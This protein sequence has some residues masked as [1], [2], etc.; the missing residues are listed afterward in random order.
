MAPKRVAG[1][2]MRSSGVGSG[3]G[4]GSR[5]IKHSAAPK[6]EPRAKAVNVRGVSQ[7]G[8]SMGNHAD[9]GKVSA[10]KAVEPLYQGKGYSTPVGANTNSKPTN[11]GNVRNTVTAWLRCRNNETARP[12]HPLGL[13]RG[14]PGRGAPTLRQRSKGERLCLT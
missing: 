6:T 1:G 13:R 14:E 10:G 3:G 12:R 5:T 8:S 9:G 7:I 4:P 2:S 11:Y